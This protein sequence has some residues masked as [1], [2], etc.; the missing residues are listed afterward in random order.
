MYGSIQHLYGVQLFFGFTCWS[1]YLNANL[2]FTYNFQK[3]LKNP[4]YGRKRI[5]RPIRIVGPIEFW[6]G[7]GGGTNERPGSDHVT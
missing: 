3:I 6:R 7:W 2:T 4:A 1:F 5:C